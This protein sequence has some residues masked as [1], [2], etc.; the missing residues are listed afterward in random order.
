[1]KLAIKAKYSAPDPFRTQRS[2]PR[3]M[4]RI[5][6]VKAFF[7]IFLSCSFLGAPLQ[8]FT[9]GP[10]FST[11]I[12]ATTLARKHVS[13]KTHFCEPQPNPNSNRKSQ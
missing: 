10:P 8:G 11:F 4:Y 3:Q 12:T 13:Q 2:L 9:P 1:M 5:E 7:K 6:K